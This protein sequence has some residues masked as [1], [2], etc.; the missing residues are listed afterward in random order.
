MVLL[1]KFHFQ[2]NRRARLFILCSSLGTLRLRSRHPS[3]SIRST[4]ALSSAA[5]PPLGGL[6]TNFSSFLE[7][8]RVCA[9]NFSHRRVVEINGIIQLKG[10]EQQQQ[11]QPQLLN[12]G[13]LFPLPAAGFASIRAPGRRMGFRDELL[14]GFSKHLQARVNAHGMPRVLCVRNHTGSHSCNLRQP[15]EN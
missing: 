13:L 12:E 1:Y 9:H 3:L 5:R 14:R 10:L 6:L 15:Q 11:Q 2:K 7:A 4:V 8:L